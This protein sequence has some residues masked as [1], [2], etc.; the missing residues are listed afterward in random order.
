M[1]KVP[2]LTIALALALLFI[3]FWFMRPVS[4]K[5]IVLTGI[6]SYTNEPSET[7]FTNAEF[8]FYK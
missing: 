7:Q 5:P 1:H 4:N 6:E 2:I 8:K 3:L